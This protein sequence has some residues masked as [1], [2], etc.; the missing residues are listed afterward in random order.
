MTIKQ[1]QV[2][3]ASKIQPPEVVLA[4][5]QSLSANAKDLEPCTA[6]HLDS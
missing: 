3:K 1:W 4:P 6:A 2:T 5:C